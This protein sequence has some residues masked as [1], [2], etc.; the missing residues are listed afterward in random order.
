MMALCEAGVSV[1]SVLRCFRCS[2]H[3]GVVTTS[4]VAIAMPVYG[5]FRTRMKRKLKSNRNEQQ[6]AAR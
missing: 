6:H 1:A 2:D 3:D 4:W 5:T